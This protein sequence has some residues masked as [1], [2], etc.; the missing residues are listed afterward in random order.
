M[1]Q[2]TPQQALQRTIEHREIFHDEMLH[3]MRMIMGG[4]M[5]PTMAAAI[6]KLGRLPGIARPG[7]ASFFP[8]VNKPVMLEPALPRFAN[9]GDRIV[10]QPQSD[11]RDK[12]QADEGKAGACGRFDLGHRMR[13]GRRQIGEPQRGRKRCCGNPARR[14]RSPQ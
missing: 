13:A 8:T 9:I 12:P 10:L 5:S 11:G 6:R 3:L 2:I 1:T 4:E 7:I 14:H